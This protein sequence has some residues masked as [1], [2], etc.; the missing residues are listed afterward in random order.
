VRHWL[1]E[2]HGALRV[3]S[4]DQPSTVSSLDPRTK[5]VVRIILLGVFALQLT[6]SD[7]ARTNVSSDIGW[8]TRFSSVISET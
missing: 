1:A 4:E 5:S 8:Q 3:D 7:G 2:A 6:D